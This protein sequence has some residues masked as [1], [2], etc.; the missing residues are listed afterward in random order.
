MIVEIDADRTQFLQETTGL[1]L[2]AESVHLGIDT[3]R[4]SLEAA[5]KMVLLA[6][7]EVR[8]RSHLE[9]RGTSNGG[10]SAIAI[11]V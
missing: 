4:I 9:I 2:Q 1:K 10:A 5:E 11:S 3:G 6:V 8:G 7:E